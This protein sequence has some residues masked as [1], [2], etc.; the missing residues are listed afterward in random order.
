[1]VASAFH[2]SP[3]RLDRWILGASCLACSD[4]WQVPGSVRDPVSKKMV[5]PDRGN[6]WNPEVYL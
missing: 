3:G 2:L 6:A 5:A 4:K 1:M